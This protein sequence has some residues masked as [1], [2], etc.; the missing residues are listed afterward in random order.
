MTQNNWVNLVG[1]KELYNNNHGFKKTWKL[2]KNYVG[3]NIENFHKI[4]EHYCLKKID[5]FWYCGGKKVAEELYFE[6][7]NTTYGSIDKYSIIKGDLDFFHHRGYTVLRTNVPTKGA[8][9]EWAS[10]EVV[11][12]N[13]PIEILAKEGWFPFEVTKHY[14]VWVQSLYANIGLKKLC[15]TVNHNWDHFIYDSSSERINRIRTF[16]IQKTGLPIDDPEVYF[17]M[18]ERAVR[19]SYKIIKAE[20]ADPL[21]WS[22]KFQG[23]AIDEFDSAQIECRFKVPLEGTPGY[24][25][26]VK[27]K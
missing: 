11:F 17:N 21:V 20:N 24:Y 13:Q 2:W 27:S 22:P 10:R 25:G 15:W 14:V 6:K 3:F 16:F 26:V 5:S 18:Y 9:K 1:I 12:R 19:N 8:D 7:Q 23:W 4:A